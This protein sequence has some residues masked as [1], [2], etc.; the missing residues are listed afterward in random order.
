DQARQYEVTQYP[1]IV[2]ESQKR[3]RRVSS[4]EIAREAEHAFTS[5]IMEVTGIIQ[6][7]VYFLTGHG[8]SNIN[9]TAS[10]GYDK[11]RISLRDNLYQIETL[12]LLYSPSIPEDCAALIISGP[13]QALTNDEVQIIERYLEGNGRALFLIDPT[14]PQEINQVLSA[15]GVKMGDGIIIDQSSYVDPNKDIPLVTRQGNVFGLAKI[16]FPGATAILPQEQ[17]AENIEIMAT[18][19]TGEN[20]WLEKDLVPG[21]EPEFNEEEDAKGPLAIGVY[22]AAIIS[23]S[24]EASE[25]EQGTTL[26]IFGD[27]DFASNE[28]FYNGNNSDLFITSI[29]VITTGTELVSIERKVL[30]F[31]RLVV[32][33]E[34]TNIIRYTS[35]GLLPL[36]VLIAGGVIWWRRR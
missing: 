35:I 6:K 19:W 2:F 32:S 27:S 31:R 5:A 26:I 10:D 8:E 21:E 36:L 9:S 17:V 24:D 33:A 34:E 7:K 22:I 13:R 16:F 12:D 18:V 15:W 30:P 28:H 4:T 20:S 29:N 3:Y 25:V 1:A 14:Y 23:G 11:A